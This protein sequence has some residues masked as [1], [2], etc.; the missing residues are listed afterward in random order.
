TDV[1][2]KGVRNSVYGID[3]QMRFWGNSSVSAWYSQV[4]DTS[5]VGPSAAS[6]IK[7]D[8]RNDRYFLTT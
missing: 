7:L 5:L 8:L 6:M 3:G 1:S 2:S 4:D